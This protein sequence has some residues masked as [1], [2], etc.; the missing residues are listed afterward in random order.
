MKSLNRFVASLSLTLVLGF[1]AVAGEMNSP[2]CPA[3]DP[4][5]M[6]SPPCSTAQE[7]SDDPTSGQ[8]GTLDASAVTQYVVVDTTIDFV[9]N[10]LSLF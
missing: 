8:T 3:P 2:P 10:V 4:G 9:E 1:S 5:E 7:T 6:S